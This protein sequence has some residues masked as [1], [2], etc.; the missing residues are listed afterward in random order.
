MSHCED[1]PCCGHGPPPMGDGGGCPTMTASGP[2]WTCCE[3]GTLMPPNASSSI[4][5]G[6][7]TRQM[8]NRCGVS[9]AECYCDLD[10]G[11][12]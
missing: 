1:Y 11:G 12:Y 6:C 9:W 8:C 5:D 4:C 2:R 7:S 3:C 10:Q